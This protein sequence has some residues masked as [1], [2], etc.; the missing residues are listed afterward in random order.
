MLAES[1]ATSVT[2]YVLLRTISDN[3]GGTYSDLKKGTVIYLSS[4]A[5]WDYGE[6]C[7]VLGLNTKTTLPV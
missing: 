3:S 5:T 2:D 7:G 4:N 6:T 1:K